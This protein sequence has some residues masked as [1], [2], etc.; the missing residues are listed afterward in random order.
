[1]ISRVIYP[2]PV[3]EY[4]NVLLWRCLTDGQVVT[5]N[6]PQDVC[7]KHLG[8]KLASPVALS[9]TEKLML[10]LGIIQ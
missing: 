8:H 9:W 3:S 10:R 2:D 1:M 4:K 6:A 5:A 7:A